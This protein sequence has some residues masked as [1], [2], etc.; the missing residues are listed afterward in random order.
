M[1]TASCTLLAIYVHTASSPYGNNALAVVT[2]ETTRTC[3]NLWNAVS[4][5]FRI[6]FILSK[7]KDPLTLAAYPAN[8]HWEYP[9]ARSCTCLRLYTPPFQTLAFNRLPPHPCNP[10]FPRPSPPP[11]L[12]IISLV[13][14][15]PHSRA[16]FPSSPRRIV[17]F[18]FSFLTFA[19]AATRTYHAWILWVV[20]TDRSDFQCIYLYYFQVVQ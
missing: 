3:S 9:H 12:P 19:A 2:Y 20:P 1:H 7:A 10:C 16:R 17:F 5:R 18:L 13:Q 4:L 15:P 14:P 8:I 6:P 11:S